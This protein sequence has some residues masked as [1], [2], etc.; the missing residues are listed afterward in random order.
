MYGHLFFIASIS[1]GPDCP[2]ASHLPQIEN[3]DK[4]NP[5]SAHIDSNSIGIPNA[6]IWAFEK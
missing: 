2:A 4:G 3:R 1:F 5:T 6:D